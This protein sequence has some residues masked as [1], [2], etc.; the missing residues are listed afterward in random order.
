MYYIIKF[1]IQNI[2]FFNKNIFIYDFNYYII[3]NMKNIDDNFFK[4]YL[5]KPSCIINYY[6][7]YIFNVI[8]F[9]IL[10]SI[11]YDF[12]VFFSLF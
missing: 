6:L 10:Q 9:S 1:N 5:F 3:V 11:C 2:L 4:K 8:H 12:L 7:M